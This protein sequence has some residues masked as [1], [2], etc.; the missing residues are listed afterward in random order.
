LF[1][2]IVT[3]MMMLD[4]IWYGWYAWYGCIWYG[5]YGLLGCCGFALRWVVAVWLGYRWLGKMSLFF[6]G[7]RK[8]S[9]TAE[10]TFAWFAST[11]SFVSPGC[12]LTST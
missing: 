4:G 10:L 8:L 9:T 6:F 12:A 3:I 7:C 11:T 1:F 2:L 5:W